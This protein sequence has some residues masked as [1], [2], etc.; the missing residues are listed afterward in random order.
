MEPSGVIAGDMGDVEA[1]VLKK[2]CP[3][4]E[5]AAAVRAALSERMI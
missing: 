4:A 2:P 5:L 1:P 3:P